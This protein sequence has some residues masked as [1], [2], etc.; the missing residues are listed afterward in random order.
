M[1]LRTVRAPATCVAALLCAGVAHAATTPIHDIQGTGNTSPLAGQAVTTEG[2]VTARRST[3]FYL[4][5]GDGESDADANT[6]EGIF[7]FTGSAPPAGA[8]LGNRVQ[9]QGTVTE[10]ST[11]PDLLTMTEITSPTVSVISSGN[12]LPTATPIDATK[13]RA[14]AL[15]SMEGLEGM[16]VSASVV[17]VGPVGGTITESSAG[18]TA[19][20]VFYAT[21]PATARPLR[22]EGKSVLDTTPFP[23]GVVPPVF[24]GNPERLR[25][26]SA[27]LQGTTALAVDAGDTVSGLVGVLDYASG[28]YNLL[29][30]TVDWPP[31][32]TAGATV[33][34]A[35]ARADDEI[36]IAGFTLQRFFDATDDPATS[37][38]VL[39]ASAL[40]KRLKKA[41]N[42]I[43]KYIGLPDI[44]GVVEVENLSV[45]QQLAAKIN[46]GD[47]QE[48]GACTR[49]PGY[50]AQLVEGN[51]A[52]GLD[53]G[54]LV[55]TAEVSTGVA[56]VEVLQASQL[57]KATTFA[58]PDSST[59]PLFD[60][61]PL[62][63]RARVHHANGASRDVTA[64]VNHLLP[65][66]GIESTAAGANGWTTI[67]GRVR[68][69]RA[70]QASDLADI[71]SLRQ[72]GNPGELLVLLGNFNAYEF[73]D[74]YVD[75]MGIISGSPAPT[76]TVYLDVGSPVAN[77]FND[78]STLVA[79]AQR[80]SHS[81]D[82]SAQS[83]DHVLYS[84]SIVDAGIGVRGGFARI[85]ADFGVDNY[86]DWTV[87]VRVSD[88]DPVV[89][90]LQIAS[91]TSVDLSVNAVANEAQVLPGATATF[92]VDV[93]NAGPGTAAPAYVSL[94][95][96]ATGTSFSVVADAGWTCAAPVADG[97]DGQRIDCSKATFASG[98]TA[99]FAV[100]AQA[101]STG[102]GTLTL[103]ATSDASQTD[104]AAGND[105]DQASEPIPADT[106]LS[107]GDATIT[108]GNSGTKVITFTVSLSNAS[109]GAVTYAI[110]T[111]NGT[112]IAGSDYVAKSATNQSI[113]AGQ[114]SKTFTVT[115]N[116]DAVVEPDETFVVNVTSVTGANVVDAQGTGTITNDDGPTLS[117]ADAGFQEGNSGTRT[118]TFTVT[119]SQASIYA[120]T[121]NIYTVD[122]MAVA[123]SDYVGK[124]LVGE[125]IPAGQL[126]KTFSITTNGDTSIEGNET[127]FVR[128]ANAS[129]PVTD[130]QARG[131]LVNDDGP[132]LS[133]S[134]A[135]VAEGNS[136]TK[137]L[138]FT[139][140]LSQLASAK[141]TFNFATAA[142]TAAAGSDFDPVS[143]TGLTIPYGQLSKTVSVVVRGDTTVEPNE[144]FRGNISLGNVSIVDG[145]GI[146]TI[147]ND[148]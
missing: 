107:V 60:H 78:L 98:A 148:D 23:A 85:N 122:G 45:L 86:G 54:F 44:L 20:G 95:V 119:L 120:V 58:N 125:S 10:L 31:T 114:L 33:V 29:P 6:S 50:V 65:M 93:A 134:D 4:Q 110:A 89:I 104:V 108:E 100:S 67:G 56:R 101:G 37:D 12:S 61:P 15:T 46:A 48:V 16:L 73:S 24:D 77:P 142:V 135:S 5:L 105:S 19:D 39:T 69:K 68:A 66:T 74:G 99:H 75:T 21:L 129:V 124:S 9:V 83:I 94:R 18:A 123:G 38:A 82:G 146:G 92:D 41:A 117:I 84:P 13:L 139:V 71:V 30:D 76:G 11:S 36:S 79:A 52:T 8:A 97:V 53:V 25:V 113:P 144:T 47:T 72:D 7:V 42:A 132:V 43:C 80:Y 96:N 106:D 140:S 28:T 2:I 59:E 34:A 118:L 62:L 109:A 128:L 26:Q 136:G 81:A 3:G 70:A 137:L 57:D 63:L 112:A 116:G 145:V 126:T 51:D 130:G 141:V 121:Y 138:T 133:I 115:L 87:P 32:V 103:L 111:A 127:L 90:F 102:G 35:P 64:I 88:R 14:D 22:E 27:G 131:M 17:V 49:N 147:T 40:D 91:F 55:S 143:V 1:T